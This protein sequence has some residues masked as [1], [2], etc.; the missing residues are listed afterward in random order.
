MPPHA[1]PAP[2]AQTAASGRRAAQIVQH[3]FPRIY[4]ACHTRHQRK[5]S[6]PHRL[7]PRDADIL[8]HLDETQSLTPGVLARHLDVSRST[9]SEAL[10]RL[11]RLGYVA[12]EPS[13]KMEAPRR[14]QRVR[15]TPQGAVALGDTSVLETQ[16]L[17]R[18]LRRLPPSS[19]RDVTAAFTALAG[20]CRGG[21][22]EAMRRRGT[23]R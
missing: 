10:K 2:R 6:T 20:A 14:M 18:L 13:E 5:R 17:E 15:L 9:L 11:A 4:L 7:S 12:A 19:L 23:P 1:R 22:A 3:A 16:R 8:A 21:E